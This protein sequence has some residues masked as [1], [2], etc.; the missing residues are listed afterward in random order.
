MIK[1]YVVR[2]IGPHLR[3]WLHVSTNYDVTMLEHDTGWVT[4]RQWKSALR[5][6]AEICY[7][8][9]RKQTGIRLAPGEYTAIKIGE[10]KP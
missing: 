3:S 9:F 7:A 1:L 6:A 8:D 5:G 10:T 2:G 4:L